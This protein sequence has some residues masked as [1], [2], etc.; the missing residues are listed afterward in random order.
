[1]SLFEVGARTV[2]IPDTVGYAMSAEFAEMI[3]MLRERVRGIEN[4]TISVHCHN[5]LGLAVANTLAALAAGARQ[6]ECTINGIGE[7]ARNASLEEIVMATR[8]RPDW[9]A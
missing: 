7:R 9:N 2:N 1:M 4:I 5:D 8:V 3:Q 6:V